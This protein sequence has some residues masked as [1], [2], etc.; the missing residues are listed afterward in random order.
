MKFKNCGT[1]PLGI[2]PVV[3][4]TDKLEPLYECGITTT[5]LRVKDL[6]EDAL[7]NEILRRL[8]YLKN[9]MHD[10]LLMTIGNWLLNIMLMVF[11]W[12]KRIF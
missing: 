3:D 1:T 9:I 11:I 7:E 4:R 12:D 6:K 2:Y 8:K 5:Q 10:F